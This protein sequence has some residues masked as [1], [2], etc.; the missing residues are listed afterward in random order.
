M[1]SRILVLQLGMGTM[2]PAVEAW[3][4]NHWTAREFLDLEFSSF[5]NTCLGEG[6]LD[7]MVAIFLVILRSLYTILHI[8]CMNLHFHQQYRR[9][10]FYPHLF[11][12]LLFVD[13]LI[14]V[15]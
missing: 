4:P 10:L 12:Y 11:Q 14:H 2:P 3:S 15:R 9:V 5:L 7:H 8:G 1:A 13:F 6:S